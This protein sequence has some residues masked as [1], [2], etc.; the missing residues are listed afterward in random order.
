M[1]EAELS[2]INK[3]KKARTGRFRY[4]VAIG[5]ETLVSFELLIERVLDTVVSRKCLDTRLDNITA[6]IKTFERPQKLRKLVGSIKRHYPGLKIIVVDDSKEPSNLN[7]V[8]TIVLPYDSGVSA[9]RNAGLEATTS[10]YMLCL[11]DDFIFNRQ[12]DL[13]SVLDSMERNPDIDILAGEV[14]Y[15]P[16]RIT[17]DY[18][19]T[20]VFPT[21]EKPIIEPGTYI[22]RFRVHLKVPNFYIGRTDR[23]RLVGW[24]HNLKRL[25]HADFFTRAVGVLVTVQDRAFKVLHYPTYFNKVYM[26]RKNDNRHDGIVLSIKYKRNEGFTKP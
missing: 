15:L 16:L 21:S 19:N 2:L 18:T 6:N 9:G 23:V 5:Y 26:E 13:L 7:G 24:D 3:L 11:D 8:K 25:D 10:K 20:P 12:T 14:I 22:D 1:R 4:V 17:H